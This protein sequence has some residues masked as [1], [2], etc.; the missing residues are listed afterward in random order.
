MV[1]LLSLP[2]GAGQGLGEAVELLSLQLA[3]FYRSSI[4]TMYPIG[5]CLEGYAG[6]LVAHY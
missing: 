6:I 4:H 5:V 3:R 1:G 2:A